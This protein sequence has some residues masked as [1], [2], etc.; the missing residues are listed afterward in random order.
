MVTLRTVGDLKDRRARKKAQTR[1]QIQRVA[2][3]LFAEHGFETVTIADI[4]GQAD[5]AVQTVFNHFPT[6]EDLFFADRA[7]WV[8]GAANAVRSRPRDMAPLIALREHLLS[9]IRR[10]L[11]APWRTRRCAPSSRPWTPRPR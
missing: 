7:D 6:K 11:E 3:P 4:A 5:V 8:E 9:T 10:Y 1:E 2:Q